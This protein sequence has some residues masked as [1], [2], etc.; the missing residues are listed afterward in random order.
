[1]YVIKRTCPVECLAPVLDRLTFVALVEGMKGSTGGATVDNVV[2]LY[3][4]GRLVEIHNIS[5]GRAGEIR[6]CLVRA[7]LVDR[8]SRPGGQRDVAPQGHH[9][10]CGSGFVQ[11]RI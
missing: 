3:E 6:S 7:G 8:D 4:R 1:M 5:F 10:R 11:A 9:V 2:E